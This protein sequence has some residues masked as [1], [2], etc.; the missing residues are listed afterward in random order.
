[1]RRHDWP[2]KL[3]EYI[4]QSLNRE[5]AYGEFDCAQF[6]CG[7]VQAMT[8]VN[9]SELFDRYS[10]EHE[11]KQIAAEGL[12]LLVDSVLGPSISSA[13]AQRGDI[14]YLKSS[15]NDSFEYA[16]GVCVGVYSLTT[17]ARG[18]ASVK[19]LDAVKAWRVE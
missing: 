18:L 11:A 16:L 1:M 9:Y 14:V 3:A 6:C 7:A 5:F 17:S 8:G 15:Q 10:T 4:A 19:T 2:E 12:D 13:M